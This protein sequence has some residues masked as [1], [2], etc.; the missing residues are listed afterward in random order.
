[1]DKGRAHRHG[2]PEEC[3]NVTAFC[4]SDRDSCVNRDTIRAGGGMIAST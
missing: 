3:A 2:P 4:V 1:M